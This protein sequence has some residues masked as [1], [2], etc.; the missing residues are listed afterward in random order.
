MNWEIFTYDNG[1]LLRLVLNGVVAVCGNGAFQTLIRISAL[2]GLIFVLYSLALGL[3]GADLRWFF[4]FLFVYM[5]LFVPKVDVV[6]TDRI[7]PAQS[8]VVGNVPF[9]LGAFAGF[10]SLVG[11]TLT[12][13]TE[14]VFTLPN[15]LKYQ[16]N[17]AVFASSLVE[18]ASQYEIT[19]PDFAEN[20]SAFMR[21]CVFYDL[22]Q[23]LYT[24]KDILEA[25]DTWQF[26]E[27][28]SVSITRA[29]PYTAAGTTVIV[30]CAAGTTQLGTDW[31]AEVARASQ[32]YGKRF[33]P[34]LNMATAQAKLLNDLPVSYDYLA[35]I[36]MSGGDIIRQ[37]MMTNFFR[38]AI[39][40]AASSADANAATQ[41]FALAQA[42]RTQMTLFDTVGRMMA[43]ILPMLK[44]ILEVTVYA[45]FPF[46]FLIF[47]LPVGMKLIATYAKLLIWL[48][49][50]APFYAI[51]NLFAS[52]TAAVKSS[53]AAA[54]VGGVEA[55]SLA[56]HSG[57]HLVNAD[58]AVLAGYLA[59]FIPVFT[60]GLASLSANIGITALAG[61]V[62]GGTQSSASS[63]SQSAATGNINLANIG[64]YN[65]GMF[66]NTTSPVTDA[67]KATVTD[68]GT[69]AQ[70]SY[71]LGGAQAVSAMQSNLGANLNTTRAS[72]SMMTAGVTKAQQSAARTSQQATTTTNA[73]TSQAIAYSQSMKSGAATGTSDTAGESSGTKRT[74]DE[75]IRSAKDAMAKE[76]YTESQRD[77]VVAGAIVNGS[78]G[79]GGGK[80]GSPGG[81]QLGGKLGGDKTDT[82]Q[83]SDEVG[84]KLSAV[85][86]ASHNFQTEHGN[87]V[88]HNRTASEQTTGDDARSE[89]LAATLTEAKQAQTANEA[90]QSNL[91]SAEQKSQ[92]SK[93]EG[94]R[95]DAALVTEFGNDFKD[96]GIPLGRAGALAQFNGQGMQQVLDAWADNK[97][98]K[99]MDG[100][101]AAHAAYQ[102]LNP[103]AGA[104]G[105]SVKTQVEN[106]IAGA[107][108]EV[109]THA[110]NAQRQISGAGAVT[111][112]HA[113]NKNEVADQAAAAGLTR[114][115]SGAVNLKP[116]QQEVQDGLRD[117]KQVVSQGAID[118]NKKAAKIEGD[119][120][121]S[122]DE[123][124]RGTDRN[125]FN[126]GRR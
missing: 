12:T 72:E 66:K 49:L 36:S 33:F 90:A 7:D 122:I 34:R 41:D 57:L 74:L 92:Q 21:Q 2:F 15:D 126:D 31:A 62:T 102:S 63:A 93:S 26:I 94:T 29:F 125:P 108:Q 83:Y 40:N 25:P 84:S 23:H 56:T 18:S 114:V 39:L 101:A 109:A 54:G 19:D 4:Q 100:A 61:A 88:G 13:W 5:V 60:W 85:R 38:R 116:V 106:E 117:Q 104:A 98:E 10:T 68:P 46:V 110:S 32:L 79:K 43:R 6:V 86:A 87:N 16:Q 3:R 105:S 124:K 30:T 78:L 8:G 97:F 47:L 89:Q 82:D 45:I 81:A 69:G 111:Q 22:L 35:N 51:L 103:G 96:A 9:A 65:T 64:A 42:E 91:V 1:E 115:G 76:G 37:N 44:N 53:A 71:A 80:S 121:N 112:T 77:Q 59:A 17:G 123:G 70:I 67:G 119:A 107:S 95:S 11:D 14:A 99:G 118:V 50:W 48:Q 75:S 120:A 27:A 73:A 20:M 58:M 52:L 28:N 24:W 113:G 55:L